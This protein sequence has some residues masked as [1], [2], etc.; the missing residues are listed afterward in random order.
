VKGSKLRYG[1]LLPSGEG[2]DE[3]KKE[4]SLLGSLTLTSSDYAKDK[5]SLR[6]REL[7]CPSSKFVPNSIAG[8]GEEGTVE[9]ENHYA[10][11]ASF[12]RLSLVPCNREGVERRQGVM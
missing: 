11:F 2:Q 9:K 3:G 12:C 1:F 4:D 5:L 7:L 8:Y 6:E 10:L